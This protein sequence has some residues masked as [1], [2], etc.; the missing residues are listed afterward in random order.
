MTN[1]SF[2]R[3]MV[4]PVNMKQ[5]NEKGDVF[6]CWFCSFDIV[7]CTDLVYTLN[8]SITY[9][10]DRIRKILATNSAT[11][12]SKNSCN[13]IFNNLQKYQLIDELHVRDVK[14]T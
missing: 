6:F 10:Q 9:F 4:Q 3:R 5:N 11:N 12:R 8:I 1:I 7:R 14:F 2:V 13:K